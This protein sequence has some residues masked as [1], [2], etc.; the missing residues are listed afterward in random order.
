M[1]PSVQIINQGNCRFSKLTGPL[2]AQEKG[3][4]PDMPFSLSCMVAVDVF[5]HFVRQE[6]HL[7]VLAQ[8]PTLIVQTEIDDSADHAV[9]MRIIKEIEDRT[10]K[11]FTPSSREFPCVACACFTEGSCLC[12]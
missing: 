4:Y 12:L 6:K 8:M 5:G 3:W 2:G 9:G 1:C 11:F 7:D 10:G